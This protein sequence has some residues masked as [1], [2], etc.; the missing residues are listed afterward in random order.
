MRS[1]II[2]A[3]ARAFPLRVGEGLFRILRSLAGE[4]FHPHRDNLLR[5]GAARGARAWELS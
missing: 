1:R 5:L 4:D 3:A 2:R